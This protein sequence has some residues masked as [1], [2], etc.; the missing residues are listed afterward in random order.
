MR[1]KIAIKYNIKYSNVYAK[2]IIVG[3]IT[4]LKPKIHLYA[5]E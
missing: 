4:P 5:A 1:L 3:L 2:L